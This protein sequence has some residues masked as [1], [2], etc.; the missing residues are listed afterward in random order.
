VGLQKELRDAD[1]ALLAEGLALELP[2]PELDDFADTAAAVSLMD[3]VISI[4]TSVAH[5]AGSL[6]RPLWILLPFASDW[7]WLRD[8]DDSP[9]Y[10]TARLFRQ[11][12]I[13]DWDPVVRRVVAAL[14]EGAHQA[15]RS[16]RGPRVA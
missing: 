8:R 3:L 7:R 12:R 14:R 16:S 4:D 1:R 2:E 6:G 15:A 13:G 10:P 9:W 11:E 5:L